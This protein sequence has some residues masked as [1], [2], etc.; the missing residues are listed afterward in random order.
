MWKIYLWETL[1]SETNQGG[2]SELE[3]VTTY[4]Y[5][6]KRINNSYCWTLINWPYVIDWSWTTYCL[7]LSYPFL[8]R[9]KWF[10][11]YSPGCYGAYWCSHL[12]NAKW[13]F[14]C[15][16]C[17]SDACSAPFV[18]LANYKISLFWCPGSNNDYVKFCFDLYCWKSH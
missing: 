8:A 10:C 18:W 2:G 3:Y 9:L 7:T 17:W 13:C 5:C 6:V 12:Y 15:R 14:Q 11:C 16:G 4:N 1:V